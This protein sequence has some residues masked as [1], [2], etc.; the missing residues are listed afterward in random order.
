MQENNENLDEVVVI[1]YGS[2]KRSDL[3]GAVSSIK[4]DNMAITSDASIDQLMKGKAAG[5]TIL[6]TSAQPG[7]SVDIRIRGAASVG[8]GNEPLYV[9]DGFP[10]ANASLEPGNA[11][12]YSQ[13]GRNPLN[14]LNPNDV[15]SIEILKDASATAIYGARATNGVILITT[16]RGKKGIKL[17]YDGSVTAQVISKPFDMLNAR[18]Y[19]VETNRVMREQWLRENKL[20]PFGTN[21]PAKATRFEPRFKGEQIDNVGDG[22]NWW[23]K[24]TRT[25]MV[26][27]HNVSIS[28]GNDQIKSYVSFGY[29]NNQGVVNTSSLERYSAKINLDWNINKYITV[30]LS[31]LGSLVNNNNIQG[32]NGEWGDSGMLMSAMLFD[33]SVPVR[34]EDGNYSEMSWY[35]NMPNPVSFEDVDDKTKQSRNLL[36][37]YL[38]IE[39]IKD[40]TVKASFGYD[41]QS[42]VR[43]NYF[44]TTFLLGKLREGQASIG[45]VNREDL[46]F[47]LVGTYKF[48][49]AN[50]RF[51][52]MVGYAYQQ[53]S[54]DGYSMLG[55]KFFTDAFLYHNIGV[56]TERP[57]I[58]SYKNSSMLASYFGR[59]NY[60][61][62]ERYLLTINMRY[63]GSDKFGK[64]N[65]W[66]FFP[67]AS[68]GWRMTEEEF[69]KDVKWV[70]NLKPRFS[71]GQTGNSNIGSNALGF[72]DPNREYAFNGDPSYVGVTVS[73]IANPN[74]KWETSSEINVGLDFG[75]LNNRISGSFE[76]YN[77]VIS[78]LLGSR[79]L[80]SWMLVPSVS[81]NL[82]KT[83][84]QGVELT[85]NTVNIDTR[86]FR[87]TTDFTFTH[88]RDTWVERS[89]DV[90]LKP[91]Q[92]KSEPIR[93][94]YYYKTGNIIQPGQKV[95]A[96]PSAVP[97][98]IEVLDVNGFDDKMNYT[99]GPDG[100]IDE[101][102][103]VYLGSMDPDC[104]IGF[105]NSF[106]YKGIDLSIYFYGSFNQMVYNNVLIKYIGWSEKIVEHGTNLHVDAKKRWASDNLNGIYP[107]DAINTYMGADGYA[108]QKASFLRCKNITVGYTF[109]KRLL[110]KV[111][112]GLRFYAD[113]QNPFTFTN[114]TGMD[115]ETDGSNKAPYPNQRTFSF[116]MNIQF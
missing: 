37:G 52:T 78:N 80:R 25:G 51:T 31:Y 88:Y 43:K 87:W 65:K 2:Q 39:P 90:V 92:K 101:A 56:G 77:R 104:S 57:S 95:A 63:D 73:Q 29:Y 60:T 91:W 70:S 40:L 44:P 53:F 54:D 6:S 107:S 45:Q 49:N 32:G 47:D 84:S 96:M 67:S 3:T 99:G 97:G 18:D 82:G 113:I 112:S 7:G 46:L 28:Y 100:K 35:A 38:Q 62:F 64:N 75:F 85:L 15:E 33:P 103:I 105:N 68:I 111:I 10:I 72:F 76:Y 34:D 16:K 110:N 89:P 9:I 83:R 23:D 81:A 41:G 71:I 98:N 42:S 50:H 12:Q 19:M 30:G 8:A 36:N 13:G 114:W 14:S 115:P 27:N 17:S 93:S 24:I 108:W 59:I 74:L 5:V 11:S 102:D 116:G 26:N 109:P 79:D 4:T 66:A 21:D 106:S 20:A 61:L 22:T 1:G 94:V 55:Q 69:M 48:G 86:G 58:G